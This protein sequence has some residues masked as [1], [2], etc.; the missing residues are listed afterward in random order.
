MNSFSD[1][2]VVFKDTTIYVI[3]VNIHLTNYLAMFK[4]MN[5]VTK[6]Q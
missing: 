4:R 6:W 3:V 2:A 5:E 1:E